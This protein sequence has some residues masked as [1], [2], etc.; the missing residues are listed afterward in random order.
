MDGARVELAL[1]HDLYLVRG[2][3]NP[4]NLFHLSRRLQRTKLENGQ[5]Y[6]RV[7]GTSRIATSLLR[8]GRIVMSKP[9]AISPMDGDG[10]IGIVG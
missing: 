10:I 5:D 3:A 6:L 7:G 2:S 8:M 1:V 9:H 4:V